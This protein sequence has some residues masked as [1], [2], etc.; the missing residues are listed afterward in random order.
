MNTDAILGK[1]GF[2][3]NDSAF[4]YCM[5]CPVHLIDPNGY[6]SIWSLKSDT[7]GR[8]ILL[9]WLFFR[10][11][12]FIAHNGPYGDYLKKNKTL[13]RKVKDL[14]LPLGNELLPGESLDV[15]ISTSMEIENG[16]DIIGYQYLH[17]TNADVGGFRINGTVS[18]TS[19]GDIVYSLTYEWNDKIDPNF[20]Y[21][22]DRKK[23][24]FAEKWIPFAKPTDY[25]IRIS[26]DDT[27]II[28]ANPSFFNRDSGW[29]K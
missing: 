27:T 18:K 8:T 10:G 15:E 26:W 17:G 11:A 5:N 19:V 13:T 21:D 28:R 3:L 29:L 12:D 25:Y 7:E 22:S 23:V 24:E 14:I 2:L 9:W 4:C 20:T 1:V 16:E 6:S